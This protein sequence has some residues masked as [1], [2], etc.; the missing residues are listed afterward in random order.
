MLFTLVVVLASLFAG[1]AMGYG[2]RALMDQE[3]SPQTHDDEHSEETRRV[4]QFQLQELLETDHEFIE[5]DP[6][7]L[8]PKEHLERAYTEIAVLR[9]R[10]EE[11][12]RTLADS[13]RSGDHASMGG[14]G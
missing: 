3:L 11:M 4:E 2:I 8:V 6:P 13:A 9:A 5:A 14:R 12:E 1:F 7:E 10:L